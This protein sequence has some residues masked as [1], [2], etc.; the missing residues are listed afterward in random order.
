MSFASPLATLSQS[1]SQNLEE[2]LTAFRNEINEK[3]ADWYE[4]L[5][6]R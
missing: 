6:Y 5:I 4:S 2:E 3:L 1:D